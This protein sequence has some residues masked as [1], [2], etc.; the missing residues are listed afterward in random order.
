MHQEAEACTRRHWSKLSEGRP[1]LAWTWTFPCS[2][3]EV[4]QIGHFRVDRL[5]LTGHCRISFHKTFQCHLHI[6]IGCPSFVNASIEHFIVC[7]FF[8]FTCRCW[9]RICIWLQNHLVFVSSSW[10]HCKMF[11]LYWCISFIYK[12]FLFLGGVMHRFMHNK[13]VLCIFM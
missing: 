7:M 1:I 11:P 2:S 9:I 5:P 6:S 10:G 12:H 4:P 13:G 8:G 3:E